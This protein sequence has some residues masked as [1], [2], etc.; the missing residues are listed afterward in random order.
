MLLIYNAA[1]RLYFV[2]IW[3]FS[4]F[5]QKAKFWIR[6]RNEQVFIRIKGSI[7]FHFSS[8]GEFEQGRPVL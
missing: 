2:V 4:F 7:W 8:L 3:I 6:G 1:I 5:N